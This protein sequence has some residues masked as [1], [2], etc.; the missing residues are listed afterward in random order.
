VTE[1]R[2]EAFRRAV[3]PGAA[4][5]LAAVL[6]AADAKGFAVYAVGG[7][8]RDFLLGRGIADLDLIVEARAGE[9]A[10]ALGR[11]VAPGGVRLR[12]HDRFG[13]LTLEGA[14]G[15]VD[16]ATV[17]R[18]R[19]AHPGA[20]P[21]TEP[22][23]LEEDLRRRDFT[24]NAMAIPLRGEPRLV[25]PF[26]GEADLASKRLRVLHSR[27]F[28]DDPTRAIRAARYA[29]R[30]GFAPEPETAALL[31]AADLDTVSAD[32]REAEL[33]RLAAES[34]APEAYG[35]LAEWGL[36][37]L[38]TGG[39]ELAR[40]VGELMEMPLWK[41]RAERDRVV[42]AAA[43]GEPGGEIELAAADPSRPSEAVALTTA[44]GAVEMV[45]ARAHGARWL[46]DYLER[47]SQVEL[48]IDGNDLIAA[49]VTEGVALGR[50]LAEAKRRKLDGE[51]DGREQE[52]AVALAVARGH[53]AV[54]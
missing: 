16:L 52:L 39:V 27:S 19:Y 4:P 28:E 23:S 12:S 38:R 6:E 54:A 7:P 35:L 49:G 51:I 8:V 48:E 33:L 30:F 2:A 1:P 36:I 41:L 40:R 14:G 11:A 50:G 20:L 15:A 25:D 3:P 34:T 10:E 26:G 45:L 29:A 17:R 31:R 53:D 9:G 21:T 44:Y 32:R 37:E 18:E 42:H 22:G 46:D 5:L 24:V 47:W 43:T 13:T